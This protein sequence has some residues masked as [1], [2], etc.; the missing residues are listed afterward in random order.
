MDASTLAWGDQRVAWMTDAIRRWGWAISYIGGEECSRPGCE[1]EPGDDPPFGY[2]VGLF[3]LGHAELLVF[4][5]DP[6][7]TAGLLNELGS[8]VRSGEYLMPGMELEFE[9]WPH[10]VI[11]EVVPNPGEIVFDANRFYDRP[12]EAS[13]PLLQLTYDDDEG[14]YPWD[15]GY[16][17][18]E[19]QPRPGT[20]RA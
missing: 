19:L 5:L 17:T 2:T 12:A 10:K 3:G 16:S 6:E 8:T 18:P 7:D 14:R 11:P 13:V 9:D 20:F 15:D 4:G 1:C